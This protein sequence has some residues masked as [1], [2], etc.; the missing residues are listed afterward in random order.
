MPDREGAAQNGTITWGANPADITIT[1]GG[2]VSTSQPLPALP[3][4][5]GT[6]TDILQPY[7]Q[8]GWS[9]QSEVA[10]QSNPFYPIV[11]A[12]AT[13]SSFTDM[14]VWVFFAS[15]FVVLAMIIVFKFMPHILA[16]LIA[17]G[18]A[19]GFFVAIGIFPFWVIFIFIVGIIAIAI[20]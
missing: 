13:Y 17:G 19:A 20:K 3:P 7:Q 11:D 4:S 15:G 9:S 18:I 2:L 8:P 5:A 1:V 14:Q 16:M 6:T 12:L 10:L